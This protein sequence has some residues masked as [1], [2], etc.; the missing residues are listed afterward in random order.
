M[1]ESTDDLAP[2]LDDM[3]AQLE[4]A[5][6]GGRRPT[7]WLVR[8]EILPQLCDAARAQGILTGEAGHIL[9]VMVRGS[10]HLLHEGETPLLVCEGDEY[11]AAIER[12]YAGG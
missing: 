3:R 4:Q 10:W 7:N 8:L 11:H 1:S 6:A 2:M 5:T 9:G 12:M